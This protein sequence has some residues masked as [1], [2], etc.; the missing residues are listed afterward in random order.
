MT[1]VVNKTNSEPLITW[2]GGKS[3]IVKFLKAAIPK[4]LSEYKTVVE[5]FAGSCAFSLYVNPFPDQ[6]TYHLNDK[7]SHLINMYQQIL[8][9]KNSFIEETKKLFIPENNVKEVYL[10]LRQE[11]NDYIANNTENVELRKAALFLYMNRHTFNG[12]CRFN[13]KGLFNNGFGYKK[14][15]VYSEAQINNFYNTFKGSRFTCDDYATVLKESFSYKNALIYLDP[16]YVPIVDNPMQYNGVD[17]THQQQE[18]LVALAEQSP[19]DVMI[20]NHDT[21]E[22]RYLYRN[23]T[24]IVSLDVRRSFPG[25]AE[26]RVKVKELIAV[27]RKD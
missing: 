18:E 14:R 13:S 27:Y 22:T 25:S 19:N 1:A 26:A 3:T 6:Y 23:A 16:P 24:E 21:E 5:A 7:N 10:S 8:K 11:F 15:I 17:F 2:V 20:S 4:P 12:L 9:D